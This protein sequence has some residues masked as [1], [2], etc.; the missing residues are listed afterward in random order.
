MHAARLDSGF[1]R[2]DGGVQSNLKPALDC[3]S[4]HFRLYCSVSMHEL[5]AL[6][7]ENRTLT[8]E[9]F[10]TLLETEQF[11][12]DLAARADAVRREYY[13]T[14]V[15]LRGLIEFTNYCKND[16]LYCG[17]RNAN[18]TL[19]RYRL[20]E[21]EILNCCETGYGLGFRTFVL[22]G[23]DDPWFNDERML[24]IIAAIRKRYE[25]CAITL[26]FGEKSAASY[27]AFFEAGANRYLLRH[28]TANESHYRQ[29]HPQTMDM[30]KRQD[31]LWSLKEI[32]Y[33]VGSGFMV[34]SPYQTTE[35]LIA[36]LRFFQQLRPDM[37]GI[38]PFIAH[39]STP[40][41]DFANGPLRLT[42]RMIAVI[43]LMFPNALIPSTTAL[44]TIDPSG[45]EYGLRC[46]ANVLMPNLSPLSVRKKYELYDNKI[47]TDE[48]AAECRACLERRV[49]GAG[50]N[51]VTHIGNA[52]PLLH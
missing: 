20:S 7:H 46:G 24:H 37:I 42:L 31:C 4:A 30:K 33:E 16:C 18:K 17:I 12:A 26:S 5:P 51:V 47:C 2:N 1:R 32:G 22:Q 44:G 3:V 35:C 14:D 9:Q 36:D 15:Y 29:L 10:M 27:R 39:R 41:S 6:L 13:G 28:E 40:F 34:G 49:I 38:G 21:T 25:D 45:R 19:E 23:G 8:D 48:E 43:R 52:K 50:Y 11:D